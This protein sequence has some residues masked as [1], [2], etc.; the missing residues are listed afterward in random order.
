MLSRLWRSQRLTCR[1]RRSTEV[2]AWRRG[3]G[4]EEGLEEEELQERAQMRR[5]SRHWRTWGLSSQATR[6]Y[7]D[8]C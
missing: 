7:A 6:R 1:R 8:V 3:G 2:P 4:V 5:S